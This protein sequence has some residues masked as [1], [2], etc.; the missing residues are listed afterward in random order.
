MTLTNQLTSEQLEIIDQII[1]LLDARQRIF[2]ITGAGMS[3]DSGLP[4]YRG[5]GGLYNSG[6]TEQGMSIEQLLSGST[7]R[8]RPELTWKYLGQI[9]QSA[10]GAEFNRGHQVLAEME[11]HFQDFCVLTQNIDGFHLRAGSRNVIEIHGNIHDLRCEECGLNQ[12]VE[13]FAEIE[14][15]PSCP[16][17]TAMMRPDVVLFDE[18]LPAA[19]IAHL[20]R[21]WDRGFDIVMSIGTTSVFPYIA[22]PVV[23]ASQ[24]GLVSIEINPSTTHVSSLCQFQVSSPA[25]MALDEIWKRYRERNSN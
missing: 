6:E 19:A 23:Y 5:V 2:V 24:A 18:M 9:G 13:H 15:P 10:C 12:T 8:R 20:Q 7:F 17:C 1:E 16:E 4:T 3:A 11:E 21:Q 25:A 14:I 22:E